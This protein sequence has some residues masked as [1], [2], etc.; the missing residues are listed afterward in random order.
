M[1]I[2]KGSL[3]KKQNHPENILAQ[4]I[5]CAK[6]VKKPV[7]VSTISLFPSHLHPPPYESTPFSSP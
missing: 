5:K 3:D 1:E 2:M 7:L 4:I 6:V